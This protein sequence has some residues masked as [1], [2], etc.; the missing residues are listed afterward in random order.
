MCASQLNALL[1]GHLG[2]L[3]ESKYFEQQL[4][5]AWR[6]HNDILLF[7]LRCVPADGLAAVPAGSRGRE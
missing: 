2:D 1:C 6:R 7:L 4:L 3:M 5:R